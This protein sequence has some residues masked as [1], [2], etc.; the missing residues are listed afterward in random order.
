V[1]NIFTPTR[2]PLSFGNVSPLSDGFLLQHIFLILLRPSYNLFTTNTQAP[3]H[4][5]VEW[6]THLFSTGKVNVYD[7]GGSIKLC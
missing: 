4:A 3:S 7:P 6:V 2:V 1:C 5:Y